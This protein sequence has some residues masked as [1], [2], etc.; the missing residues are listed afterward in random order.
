MKTCGEAGIT[1]RFTRVKHPQT[2]GKA[3]RVI[4]TLMEGWHSKDG[5]MFSSR[6][7][8]AKALA[9]FVNYY[10]CVRPHKG[11]DRATPLER[12]CEYFYQYERPAKVT[13]KV[14]QRSVF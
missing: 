2:N 12:L 1:Q 13:R 9:R 7:E 4:R 5:E 8:R 3:E 6:Q 10:N 11:I 14:K